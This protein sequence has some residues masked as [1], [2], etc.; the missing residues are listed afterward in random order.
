VAEHLRVF[1]DLCSG[2]GGAS[3]AF[4][5]AS[6]WKAIRIESN[7]ALEDVPHTHILDVL[8]WTDWID[9]FPHP[10]VIWASPP[11]REFSRAYNAPAPASEREG[12]EFVPDL[13]IV[14][15]CTEI[16]DY[17]KP[18]WF[19]VENVQG[20]IGAFESLLG[21]PTQRI[22]PFYLWGRF[23]NI[24]VDRDFL[25][26]KSQED[27]WSTDPLR[28]NKKAKVPLEISTGLLRACEDQMT[29]QRWCE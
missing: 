27:V 16:I 20:A 17:F 5:S 22:G 23:P 18:K 6:N 10:E 13:S 14:R 2:L 15:A 28:A 4:V 19:I 25:H 26:T 12:I 7:P 29:L 1:L 21:Q 9:R 11:C 3:E 24:A 8:Q